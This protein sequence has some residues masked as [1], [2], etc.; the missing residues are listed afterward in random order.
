MLFLTISRLWHTLL[1]MI[2]GN[3]IDKE[4]ISRHGVA[5]VCVNP[6]TGHH[7][8]H[9]AIAFNSGDVIINFCAGT[10]QKFATYLTIQT[11]VDEHITLEPGYLQYVNHSCSPNVFFDTSTFELVAL[12]AI[13]PG[14]ELCFF[15]PSTEWEMAQSFTCNCSIDGCLHFIKGAAYLSP[16]MLSKY[17]LTNFILQQ[18]KQK[19]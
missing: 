19:T 18:L 2:K 13:M 12:K 14:K 5:D 8:L 1:N 10:T 7:S 6:G 15:Y 17:K 4:I 9:A 16:E 11:G 3:T